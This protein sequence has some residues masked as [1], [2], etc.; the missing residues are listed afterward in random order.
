MRS[1]RDTHATINQMHDVYEVPKSLQ[2]QWSARSYHGSVEH[3]NRAV[4]A[5]LVL[6]FI[7]PA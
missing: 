5:L 7:I 2:Q 3:N 4:A 6:G 1:Q